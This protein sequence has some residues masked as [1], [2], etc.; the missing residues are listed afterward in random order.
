M[1]DGLTTD[2]HYI[3]CL[4]QAGLHRVENCFVF[5]SCYATLWTWRALL[6]EWTLLAVRTPIP[7]QVQPFFFACK[8]P[9]QALSCR[10]AI[11]VRL[12]VVDKVGFETCQKFCVRGQ[13]F[14]VS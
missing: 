11:F 14:V 4:I 7:M 2:S 12:G 1:L 8:S 3:G 10:A 5:P 6:L 9:D 13:N